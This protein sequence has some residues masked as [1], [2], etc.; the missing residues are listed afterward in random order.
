MLT[1]AQTEDDSAF[2]KY[3]RNKKNLADIVKISYVRKFFSGMS[4]PR[5]DHVT[6]PGPSNLPSIR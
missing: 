3:N 4:R 2:Q 6:A 5:L 1:P